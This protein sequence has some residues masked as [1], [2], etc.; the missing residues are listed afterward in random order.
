MEIIDTTPETDPELE[1]IQQ[2]DEPHPA[3]RVDVNGPVAVHDLPSRIGIMRTLT[4]TENASPLLSRDPTRKAVLL[5]PLDQTLLF[6]N[7][8]GGLADSTAA[9]WPAGLPLEIRSTEAL[10][11]KCGAGLTSRLTVISEQW[12]G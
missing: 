9:Q 11:V 10:W 2:R 3:V 1:E 5:L 12:A 6:S 4:I 8:Q 7:T